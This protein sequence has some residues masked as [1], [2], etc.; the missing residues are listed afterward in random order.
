MCWLHNFHYE[1]STLIFLTNALKTLVYIF[2][3]IKV[4][5]LIIQQL[6]P[7]GNVKKSLYLL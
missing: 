3:I 7:I 1:V 6:Q 5:I 4:K 2:L